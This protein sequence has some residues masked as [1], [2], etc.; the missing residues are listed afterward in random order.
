MDDALFRQK[1]NEY[2]NLLVKWQKKINLISSSTL[3]DIEKRHFADSA[4]L[5]SFIP[6]NAGVLVD[7]G[8]GAGFPGM[9][10]ALLDQTNPDK[11][12]KMD[13]H[14]IESDL[15]KAAFLQEVARICQVQVHIHRQRIEQIKDLKADVITSRALAPLS[16]LMTYSIPFLKKESVCLFLKGE[17]SA[18]EIQEAE[19]KYRMNM[20]EIPSSVY[21]NGVILKI[22]EIKNESEKA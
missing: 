13:I 3:E 19:K 16:V 15:R 20:K 12:N 1:L 10:L 9:V 7:L 11:Q 21:E 2:K 6:E 4:Q 14:L 22:S 5:Y 17:K 8:S 18:K